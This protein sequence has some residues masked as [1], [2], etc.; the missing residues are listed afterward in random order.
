MTL[1][2]NMKKIQN[3]YDKSMAENKS[4]VDFFKAFE[5]FSKDNKFKSYP[6]DIKY[7]HSNSEFI[8][9]YNISRCSECFFVKDTLFVISNHLQHPIHILADATYFLLSGLV[10][11]PIV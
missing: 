3:I 11:L 7:V 6:F 4:T 5:L 9:S 1:V 2:I 10:I 8:D